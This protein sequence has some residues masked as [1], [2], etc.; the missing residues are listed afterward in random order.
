MDSSEMHNNP[1]NPRKSMEIHGIQ[2]NIKQSLESM[3]IHG[4]QGNAE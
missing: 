1:W 4:I 3:G 2:G